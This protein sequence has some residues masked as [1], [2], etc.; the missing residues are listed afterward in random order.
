M[1]SATPVSLAIADRR[2][3]FVLL[4]D[5]DNGPG[6]AVLFRAT[7]LLDVCV[8]LFECLWQHAGP[9][10]RGAHAV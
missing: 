6:G 5:P 9:F 3:A 2:L 10:N 1:L 8:A 4:D 7:A